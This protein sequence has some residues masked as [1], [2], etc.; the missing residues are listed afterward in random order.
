M[1]LLLKQLDVCYRNSYSQ[2]VMTTKQTYKAVVESGS[3]STD[4]RYW[5]ERIHCGHAHKT[6]AAAE[7][8]GAAHYNAR[9]VH[10]SWQANADWHGY[11]IHN[12]E[13]ERVAEDGMT[14]HEYRELGHAS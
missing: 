14:E 12:Q 1:K 2:N 13:G 9:Y 6:Y 4:Y 7:K 5:E 8:C 11:K 3:C 10:G